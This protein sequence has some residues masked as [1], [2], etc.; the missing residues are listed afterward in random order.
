MPPPAAAPRRSGLL[1][2][3][4]VVAVLGLVVGMAG[5]AI[6]AIALGRSDK[7]TTLA[8]TANNRPQPPVVVPTTAAPTAP[9][10]QDTD[11]PTEVNSPGE[12]SPTA[13][14]KVNY[15]DQ[16]LRVQSQN[17]TGGYWTGIDLDDPRVLTEGDG[18]VSFEGCNPGSVETKLQFAEVTGQAATPADCLEN[19]RTS[20]AQS[21]VAPKPELSLCFVTSQNEAAAQGKTQKVVIMT[22]DS[23]TVNN[24]HG[25]LNITL[26]AWDVPQ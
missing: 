1:V 15:Q 23:V 20:P 16:H 18:D 8:E 7:A 5:V 13:D 12:V 26:K 21:P 22:V 24:D 25:I 4:L 3:T 9:A 11:E 10:G 17:C 14:F 6:A 19:I 2:I